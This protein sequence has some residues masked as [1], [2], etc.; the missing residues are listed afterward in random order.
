MDALA[1]VS[2]LHAY[3]GSE[4]GIY[5]KMAEQFV[6]T[7]E[8]S[9]TDEND[10][11]SEQSLSSL[12]SDSFLYIDNYYPKT[13][14]R[15]ICNTREFSSS[16]EE[17]F[18][19]DFSTSSSLIYGDSD[20]ESEND[21]DRNVFTGTPEKKKRSDNIH[22]AA[23]TA[24]FDEDSR[25][26]DSELSEET[27]QDEFNFNIEIPGG[28]VD[29]MVTTSESDHSDVTVESENESSS[30]DSESS[31]ESEA[32]EGNPLLYA[33]AAVT[34]ANFDA[35]LLAL[36][37][38]HRLSESTKDDILKLFELALPEGNNATTSSHRFNKRHEDC[39]LL[40]ELRELCPS[41]YESV[42]GKM[43]MSLECDKS[44]IVVDPIMF[45]DIPLKPQIQRL[46][47]GKVD[48]YK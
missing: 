8:D 43:C 15:K 6:L 23:E 9:S 40:H 22:E 27:D 20:S 33:G 10:A 13:R 48:V 29:G 25:V 19:E 11:S 28:A 14:K 5:W 35:L 41:S 16:T 2:L 37:N 39:S 42:E 32:E 4:P 24:C 30:S 31:H 44:G 36:F 3:A 21:Q 7:S 26:S 1:R 47:S 38:K 34:S 18:S 17:N 46:I 45:Y 12:D